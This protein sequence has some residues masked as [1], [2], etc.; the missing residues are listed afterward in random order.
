LDLSNL[1]LEGS[2]VSC[3]AESLL[4]AVS[5][6]PQL[7]ILNRKIISSDDRR[8]AR[9]CFCHSL[10]QD[11]QQ[12]SP[13]VAALQLQNETLVDQQW[14]EIAAVRSDCEARKQRWKSEVH[15]L[16]SKIRSLQAEMQPKGESSR[17]DDRRTP[18]DLSLIN[19]FS[20]AIQS[21][22]LR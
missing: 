17:D 11:P 22:L 20:D 8:Q 15:E 2:P 7:T 6:L 21:K 18:T 14:A 12:W 5:I 3:G 16:W 13:E 19:H 9:R 1:D 10:S 4:V